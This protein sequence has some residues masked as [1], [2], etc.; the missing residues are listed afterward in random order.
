[1]SLKLD[2]IA[3]KQA[4]VIERRLDRL[5]EMV[6]LLHSVVTKT[7]HNDGVK[8]IYDSHIEEIRSE[9]NASKNN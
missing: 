3:Y 8:E 9:I 7:F 4:P 6:L 2:A 5:E 1:M